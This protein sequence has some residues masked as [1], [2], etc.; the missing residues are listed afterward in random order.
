[1]RTRGFLLLMISMLANPA[2]A[3]IINTLRSFEADK[4]GL[5]GG[6]EGAFAVA[7]GNTDYFE[8]EISGAVQYQSERS[9]W[10]LLGRNM[11][12]TASGAVA[13][14]AAMA[15]GVFGCRSALGKSRARTS[16]TVQPRRIAVSTSWSA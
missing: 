9:R 15:S 8:L 10:R 6:I 1:M 11:R 12:R 5:S 4:I 13:K 3:Q 16:A 7:D 2:S 14:S